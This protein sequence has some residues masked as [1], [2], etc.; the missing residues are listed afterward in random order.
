[1]KIFSKTLLA[2]LVTLCSASTAHA[3]AFQLAEV[4]HPV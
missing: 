1:M 3:A 2:S 4:Q